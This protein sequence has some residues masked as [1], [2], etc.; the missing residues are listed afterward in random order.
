MA[1]EIEKNIPIPKPPT[2]FTK[3]PFGEME[4]GDSFFMRCSEADVLKLKTRIRGATRPFRKRRN[5]TARFEVRR[6]SGGVR[7]W[8]TA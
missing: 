8:R 3:Y 5:T 4:I 2:G 1:F 7:C 6:V